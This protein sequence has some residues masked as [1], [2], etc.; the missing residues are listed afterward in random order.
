MVIG[1]S[2]LYSIL[3]NPFWGLIIYGVVWYDVGGF[4]SFSHEHAHRSAILKKA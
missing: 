2:A 1:F 4:I 3:G